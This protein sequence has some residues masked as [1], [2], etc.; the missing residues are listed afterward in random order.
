MVPVVVAEPKKEKPTVSAT[1]DG[2]LVLK[3]S[4]GLYELKVQFRNQMR[5]ESLRPTEDNRQ[6]LNKFYIPRSRLQVEGH[7]FGAE[8]RYK[9]ELS[10]DD[11][12]SFS[13]VKDMYM[14]RRVSDAPV[15]LRFGQW[16]RPFFRQEMVSDFSSEFNER[17]IAND[18][19]GGGRDLGFSV[20][21]DYEKSPEGIEWVV[22]MFNTMNGGADRPTIPVACVTAATPATPAG[23]TTTCVNGRATN[24]PLDFQPA[25][26]ARAGWN[27]PKSKG[28]SEVDLEGGPLRYSVAGAFK[29]DLA[30]FAEHGKSSV[31]NNMSKAMEV[32][33]NVK[34]YGLSFSGGAVIMFLKDADP[35][36]GFV[37][38]P[39]FMIL[40]KHAEIAAR[41]AFTTQLEQNNIEALGAFNYFFNGH[42]LKIA[43]DFGIVE[44]TGVNPVTLLSDSPDIRVRIMSQLEI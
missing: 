5:F 31:F 28:Y 36:Y 3:S 2:G 1:Y 22:G 4:D 30:N 33:W 39:G 23:V 38:Q 42:R 18:L 44:T 15:Y 14:E 8:N 40:P 37:L 10:M 43:S 19:A 35:E 21:N 6:F 7:V 13:F 12:G 26:V 41:F 16:K 17:S 9:L 20:N 25:I 24:F 29:I 34:A 27:S 32:D 11:S